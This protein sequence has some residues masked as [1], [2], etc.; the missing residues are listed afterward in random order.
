MYKFAIEEKYITQNEMPKFKYLKVDREI[1]PKRDVLTKEER[2][3][4]SKYLRYK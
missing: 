1:R 3:S 2:E 4:I